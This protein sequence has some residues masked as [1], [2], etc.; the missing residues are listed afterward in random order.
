MLD[1]DLFNIEMKDF[2]T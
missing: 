2:S 1:S